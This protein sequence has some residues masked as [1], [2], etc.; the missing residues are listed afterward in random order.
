MGWK[1]LVSIFSVYC[2]REKHNSPCLMD[3]NISNIRFSEKQRQFKSLRLCFVPFWR[4]SSHS[5]TKKLKNRIVKMMTSVIMLSD[6]RDSLKAGVWSLCTVTAEINPRDHRV[7]GSP[8]TAVCH[9]VMRD[10]HHAPDHAG[11]GSKSLSLR[12]SSTQGI[13]VSVQNKRQIQKLNEL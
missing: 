13:N 9:D 8:G 5:L 6:G 10:Y 2:E 11:A 12:D 7:T 4:N 3:Q 1:Y